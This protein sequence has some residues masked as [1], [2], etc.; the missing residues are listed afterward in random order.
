MAGW[1]G[2]V[3]SLLLSCS[4][5]AWLLHSVAPVRES[6]RESWSLMVGVGVVS[7]MV[8]VGVRSGMCVS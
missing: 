4:L 5:A 6:E 1:R 2:G 3:G 7:F 8:E